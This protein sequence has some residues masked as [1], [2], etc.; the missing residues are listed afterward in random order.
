LLSSIKFQNIV[1]GKIFL[2]RYVRIPL[3]ASSNDAGADIIYVVKYQTSIKL[4]ILKL[5]MQNDVTI[6]VTRITTSDS[7]ND[8][9]QYYTVYTWAA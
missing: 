5:A 1:D 8:G 4:Q 6:Y 3:N 9:N 7:L 2:T